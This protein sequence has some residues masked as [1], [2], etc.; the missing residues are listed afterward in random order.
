M[1]HLGKQAVVYGDA[2][3]RRELPANRTSGSNG[4]GQAKPLN[5]D[6]RGAGIVTDGFCVCGVLGGMGA[7][8]GV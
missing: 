5:L 8:T 1:E 3:W 4:R 6:P 7:N 2:F